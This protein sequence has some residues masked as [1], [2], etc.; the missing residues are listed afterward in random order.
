MPDFLTDSDAST[1]DRRRLSAM[2]F[3]VIRTL[4]DLLD[5]CDPSD[6]ATIVADLLKWH[7][8]NLATCDNSDDDLDRI[9]AEVAAKY[10]N[11]SETAP[12]APYPSPSANPM[13]EGR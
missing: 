8:T 2:I 1:R 11:G 3:K 7:T 13:G 9:L 4:P 10:G 5:R 6:S 12:S